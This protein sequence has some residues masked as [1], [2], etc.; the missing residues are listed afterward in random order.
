MVSNSKH[1]LSL[2]SLSSGSL[3]IA[4]RDTCA[5]NINIVEANKGT[6]ERNRQDEADNLNNQQLL[7]S[8]SRFQ[9]KNISYIDE[10]DRQKEKSLNADFYWDDLYVQQLNA[11]ITEL[12][13]GELE[14]ALNEDCWTQ[15]CTEKASAVPDK[16]SHECKLGWRQ[17]F[18]LGKSN[19]ITSPNCVV[20]DAHVM[21]YSGPRKFSLC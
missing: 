7:L 10:G 9:K 16:V 1:D 13:R 15:R 4:S 3:A 14:G 19:I 21:K 6:T 20:S 8:P 11:G 18:P 17:L 5:E 2:H 12:Y